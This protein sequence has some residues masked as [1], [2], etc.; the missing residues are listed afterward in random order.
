MV[1]RCNRDVSQ[2]SYTIAGDATQ[3]AEI[4]WSATPS[5]PTPVLCWSRLCRYSTQMEQHHVWVDVSLLGMRR[6]HYRSSQ[7]AISN[8]RNSSRLSRSSSIHLHAG[9]SLSPV[10]AACPRPPL[11]QR[12]Q[13][14]RGVDSFCYTWPCTP[15][16]LND[17]PFMAGIHAHPSRPPSPSQPPPPPRPLVLTTFVSRSD[18]L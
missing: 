13:T 2:E 17:D 1:Y 8:N 5:S 16:L 11:T 14:P 18:P 9:P 7:Q 12:P 4:G 10:H 6:L 3:R 15:L